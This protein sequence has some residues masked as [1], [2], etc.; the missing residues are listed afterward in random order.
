MTQVNCN[1]QSKLCHSVHSQLLMQCPA[2]SQINS[3]LFLWRKERTIGCLQTT[4]LSTSPTQTTDQRPPLSKP[5]R[6]P[7]GPKK[8]ISSSSLSARHTHT[9]LCSLQY[10]VEGKTFP[11][12]YS[13]YLS[14]IHKTTQLLPSACREAEQKL[15]R[16]CEDCHTELVIHSS[17]TKHWLRNRVQTVKQGWEV[18]CCTLKSKT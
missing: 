17:N 4:V 8:Q 11:H 5:Q 18:C 13:R 2:L 1:L 9:G 14:E 6:S 7:R 15:R 16:G 3:I 12:R 10:T